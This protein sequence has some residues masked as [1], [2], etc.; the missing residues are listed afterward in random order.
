[1]SQLDHEWLVKFLELYIKDPN[2]I[3]LV[4]KFLKAGVM[5]DGE[6]SST[7]E[8]SPQGSIVSPIL[9]N[10]YMHFVLTLWYKIKIGK[11]CKGD[12]FL[13]NYADDFIAGFQ[14]Q[15]EAESYYSQLKERM[16]KFGL[17]LQRHSIS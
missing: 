8:G 4:K 11:Q 9:A 3:W 17:D 6:F 7:D 14:Y 2:I 16:N 13:V 15:W 10:I 5:D 12:N 1:M